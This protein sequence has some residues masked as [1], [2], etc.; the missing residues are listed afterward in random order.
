MAY[1][2]NI[3]SLYTKSECEIFSSK[4][5]QDSVESGC[6][7]EYRPI[8]MLDSDKIEFLIPESEDYIDMSHTQLYLKVTIRDE[9]T[10]AIVKN[11]IKKEGDKILFEGVHVAPVNNFM[12][13]LFNHVGVELNNRS[14]THPS[15]NYHYRSYFEKLLNYSVDAKSTHLLTSLFCHDNEKDMASNNGNGFKTRKK[16][17][18]NGQIELSGFLHTELSCQ[19]KLLLNNVNVRVKLYRNKPSF[20]LVSSDDSENPKSFKIEITEALLLVRKLKIKPAIM[21]AHSIVLNNKFKETVATYPINRIDV[22]MISLP[23]E[24]Q[25]K[26]LDNVILGQLPKRIFMALVN[27]SDVNNYKTN[28]YRFHHFDIQ[29]IQLSSDVHTN[30]RPIRCNFSKGEYLQAYNSMISA[31]G[32][33][34]SD[35]GNLISREEYANGYTIAA[36]DITPDL[37]ANQ[38]HISTPKSGSLRLE[39]TFEKKLTEPIVV[40]LYCEFDSHITI[41]KDRVVNTDFS[42]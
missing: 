9:S 1:V 41:D 19:D 20:S 15:N 11:T 8:T 3:N 13:S 36:W 26:V 34:F 33:N 22:K 17:I 32:I 28:P 27:E 12:D 35:D 25:N 10:N 18:K 4:P 2:N 40:I 16:F 29:S 42:C 21:T 37:S 39:V 30:L 24:C 31:C 6:F 14:V 7:V 38:N 23:Q 5:L